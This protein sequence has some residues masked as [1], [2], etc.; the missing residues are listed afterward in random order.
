MANV[1]LLDGKGVRELLGEDDFRFFRYQLNSV[2]YSMVVGVGALMLA[3]AGYIWWY[4]SLEANLW[5]AAFAGLVAGGLGLGVW[6]AYWYA[7]ANSRFVGVSDQK[8]LV[9]QPKKA[10]AIDWSI[11]DSETLGLEKMKAT[12]M[13]GVLPVQVGGQ[14]IQIH[15]YNAYVFLGDIQGLMATLLGR[16][17]SEAEGGEEMLDAREDGVAPSEAAPSESAPS[18]AAPESPSPSQS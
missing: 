14:Q 2:G 1:Q 16:L 6:A 7:F 15:L 5:I 17:T 8:L 9:G 10:W 4:T 18:E 12:A 3:A 13:R 11:L